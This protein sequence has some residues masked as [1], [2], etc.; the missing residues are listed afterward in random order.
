MADV[1]VWPVI[2]AERK[3][4]AGDL[5]G[6]GEDSWSTTSLCGEWTI[7]DVVAH[8][9]ATSKLSAGRFLAK[10][11]GS[12][13]S[14]KRLQAR[15]IAAERGA[16]PSETLAR[17]KAQTD[18][19]GRPPGPVDTM[20]GEVIIHSED[21]RRPLGITHTYPAP[22]VVRVADFYKRSN[23]IL[24]AKDRIAGLSLQATDVDWQH[25]NGPPVSGPV[26]ALVLVMTGRKSALGEL[27]GDGVATLRARD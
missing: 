9:T 2:H 19:M 20:L 4:L 18:S 3:A 24:H 22:A 23:L 26:L 8:M 11:I 13:L 21:V 25:G 6:L 5:E 27:T 7:R 15:D 14:L 10:M 16:S 17:F 12:G 1:D